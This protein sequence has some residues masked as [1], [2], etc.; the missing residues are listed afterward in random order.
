MGS[1]NQPGGGDAARRSALSSYDM[2]LAAGPE[3]LLTRK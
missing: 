2:Q 3:D 1:G